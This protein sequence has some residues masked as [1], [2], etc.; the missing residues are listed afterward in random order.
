MD[1]GAGHNRTSR[2]PTQTLRQAA[3]IGNELYHTPGSKVGRACGMWSAILLCFLGCGIAPFLTLRPT[4]RSERVASRSVRV[5][6]RSHCGFPPVLMC[7]SPR[8]PR[9]QTLRP[10]LSIFDVFW[11]FRQKRA[12]PHPITIQNMRF[13]LQKV[14]CG[15]IPLT[16]MTPVT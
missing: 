7:G 16:M 9:E 12:L 5:A 4:S 6:L 8:G 1:L 14:F 3:I 11:P 10:K 2:Q 13:G 15:R